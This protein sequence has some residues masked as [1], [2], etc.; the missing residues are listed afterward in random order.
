[1]RELRNEAD[2]L[3]VRPG[4]QRGDPGKSQR[5]ADPLAKL[6]GAEG[7]GV[8]GHHDIVGLPEDGVRG[9]AHAGHLTPRHGVRRDKLQIR[10][11]RRLNIVDHAGFN[12]GNVRDHGAGSQQVLVFF[13]P[14]RD[15]VRVERK[16]HQIRLAQQSGIR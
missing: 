12:A 9:V 15:H 1:M 7:V 2:H 3:V 16:D 14:S 6:D 8:R 4:R 11:Q 13:D 10:P 5:F